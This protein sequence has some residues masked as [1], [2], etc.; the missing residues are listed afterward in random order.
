MVG[1]DYKVSAQYTFRVPLRDAAAPTVLQSGKSPSVIIYKPDGTL[2]ASPP[3]ASELGSS[4]I[5]SFA[6]TFPAAAGAYTFVV[7]ATGIVPVPWTVQVRSNSRTDLAV[8]ATALT[9]AT[10]TDAK[11][12]HIDAAVSGRATPADIL[13]TPANKLAVDVNG[14]VTVGANA[15]KVSYSLVPDQSGVTVGTANALGTQA[16]A[17]VKTQAG[18]AL[19]DYGAAKPADILVNPASDKIDGSLLDV[20]VSSRSALSAADVWASATR[21][22]TGGS[23]ASVSGSVGSVT[24]SVA[25]VS[26]AVTV[27]TNNDKTG[28]GLTSAYDAAKTASQAGDKM[29]LVNAPNSTALAAVASAV[30]GATTRTLTSFG[31]LVAD[32][33][34]Y[35]TRT[36]TGVASVD[37]LGT[38]AKADVRAQA[39]AALIAY[40]GATG[41]DMTSAVAPLATAAAL[42]AQGVKVDAVKAK[43]DNLPA[44]PAASGDAM[45]LTSD[46]RAAVAD[47]VLDEPVQGATATADSLRAA[48]KAA[49]AQGFGKWALNGTVLR[50]Y[51]PDGT[52]VVR[53]FNI[54]SAETPTERV[55]A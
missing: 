46:E 36:V 52:T 32:V 40:D 22:V 18:S 2:E 10:W 47:A 55:P 30:W 54:D 17:D 45:A 1:E 33:W 37:A 7:S 31:S 9:N 23:V 51:G 12:G 26:G 11:A 6:Y 19:T 41:A 21:T 25:S 38:Q 44:H 27:G 24:G 49:W 14:R 5:Y 43:T 48:A 16:K 53:Q 42:T 4:G 29:D 3:T 34:G 15:D 8:A 35:V 20:A 39:D 13:A 28:Y 50:L